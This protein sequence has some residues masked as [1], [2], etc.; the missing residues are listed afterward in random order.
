MLENALRD[1]ITSYRSHTMRITPMLMLLLLLLIAHG[2][3]SQEDKLP[4][5]GKEDKVEVSA[6]PHTRDHR[7]VTELSKEDTPVVVLQLIPLTGGG[8]NVRVQTLN[9]IWAP[10]RVDTQG[11]PGEG[12]AHLYLDGEKIARVYGEWYHLGSLP[13]S[14][15]A[16]SVA[17][18]A[19]DHSVFSVDGV[20]VG[21]SVN[22]SEVRGAEQ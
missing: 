13:E 14:A 22:I 16:L 20:D 18:Y 2:A 17:L 19:N 7:Q 11:V 1:I 8:Y 5:S 15:E 6:D 9:F 4:E 10:H 3:V 12:H 21:D